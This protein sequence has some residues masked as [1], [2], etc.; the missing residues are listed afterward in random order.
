MHTKGN[1]FP[2][3][4]PCFSFILLYHTWLPSLCKTVFSR[5]PTA[6]HSW[7][8]SIK[9]ESETCFGCRKSE[10]ISYL[11][12]ILQQGRRMGF[13]INVQDTH[14]QICFL[15]AVQSTHGEL[16]TSS[17][18]CPVPSSTEGI[19]MTPFFHLSRICCSMAFYWCAGNNHCGAQSTVQ[20]PSMGRPLW[21]AIQQWGLMVI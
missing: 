15:T 19:T 1:Y 20:A 9:M 5:A 8:I 4:L 12:C 17:A 3:K 7:E 6:L 10:K 11:K 14:F 13:L 16:L 2:I 21:G 18:Q